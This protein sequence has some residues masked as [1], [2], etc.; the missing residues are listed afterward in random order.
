MDDKKFTYHENILSQELI[1]ELHDYYYQKVIELSR[2][3]YGDQIVEA[4]LN[5]PTR[6]VLPATV[7]LTSDQQLRV[8]EELYG[9]ERLPFYKNKQILRG[10]AYPMKINNYLPGGGLPP[11]TDQ[12]WGSMTLFLN[13][14]WKE[15]WGGNFVWWTDEDTEQENGMAY[16]PKYN[17]GILDCYPESIEGCL[18]RVEKVTQERI[19][20]QAF[21]ND[22]KASAYTVGKIPEKYWHE[23]PEEVRKKYRHPDS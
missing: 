15:E 19:S 22:R 2:P 5:G 9:N 12:A 17:C 8:L 20:V 16:T 3:V 10:L 7:N 18:H 1:D 14:E 11:H 23:M 21:W 4:Y 6:L 13:K